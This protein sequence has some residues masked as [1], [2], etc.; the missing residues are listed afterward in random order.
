MMTTSVSVPAAKLRD[1][2]D[3]VLPHA[4]TDDT[5]PVLMAVRFEVT[6]GM[7]YVAATDRFT[8]AAARYVIPGAADAPVP[9]AAGLLMG[10]DARELRE[11]LGHAG[12]VAALRLGDGLRVDAGEGCAGG[13]EDPRTAHPRGW[14]FPDWR[15]VLA[16]LLAGKDAP[17]SPALGLD[18][19]YLARFAALDDPAWDV[20]E[21]GETWRNCAEP[22]VMRAVKRGGQHD[23]AG[24]VLFA[25]G[26]WFLGAVMLMGNDSAGLPESGPWPQWSA[27]LSPQPVPAGA[28]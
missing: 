28:A 23:R 24:V 17:F 7:L 14:D 4:G 20:V 13:W 16:E 11:L 3:A 2:L 6:G 25:R 1:M 8:M 12:D 26:D 22:L 5:L 18:P 21:D 10:D 15:G 27:A 9:D 19:V